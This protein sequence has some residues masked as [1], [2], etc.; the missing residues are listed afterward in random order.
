MTRTFHTLRVL[1]TEH[2]IVGAKRVVFDIPEP[3]QKTFRWRAGQHITLRFQRNGEDIRRSYTVSASPVSGENLCIT[4]KRVRKGLVSNYINDTVKAGDAIEVMPPF[5]GFC[6]DPDINKRRTH[7]FFGAGSGITPLFAMLHS[8]L[9]AEPH[10][11]VYLLYGNTHEK[12]IIFREKLLELAVAYPGRFAVCY[13]L[14]NPST[15]KSSFRPWRTGRIDA[16][17]IQAFIDEYP[18]YAQDTQYYI[19]GPGTM[20]TTLKSILQDGFDVPTTRMHSET[21]GGSVEMDTSFEGIASQ[22]T[23]TLGGEER[24]VQVQKGQTLL[25]A[26][27]AANLNPPYSCQSGLCGA[28][29]AKIIDGEV[30]MRARM[31]LE[32]TDIEKGEILTC[33][34]VAKTDKIRIAFT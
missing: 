14:S 23:I 22:T 6:L 27:L 29:R 10:S 21:F 16:D 33:Q 4:V 20:N 25:K 18:P 30:H 17:A 11:F 3:L 2:P 1:K 28:C 12:S 19:C 7:Y 9:L 34:T 26:M 5:G 32:D 8:V 24:V 13:V 31:A 15:Q